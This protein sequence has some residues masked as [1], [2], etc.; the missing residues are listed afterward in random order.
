MAENPDELL[1]T[2]NETNRR[3]LNQDLHAEGFFKDAFHEYLIAGRKQAVNPAKTGT[4]AGAWFRLTVPAGGSKIV[5]LRLSPMP[6]DASFA[7]FDRIA[8]LRR[9]EADKFY[10]HLQC[11]I[12]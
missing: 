4:K 7:D 8:D 2:D 12:A 3:R 9:L 5:R 10:A 1:F 11:D 6:Q